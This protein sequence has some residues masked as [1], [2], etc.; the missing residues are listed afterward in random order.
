[1][2][3]RFVGQRHAVLKPGTVLGVRVVPRLRPR[4]HL[5]DERAVEL[6]APTT[7]VR[8]ERAEAWIQRHSI[9]TDARVKCAESDRRATRSE[10]VSL[11]MSISESR[12][13]TKAIL[14][15]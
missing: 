13:T 7:G 8:L 12:S 10:G 15:K 11:L 14:S 1:M 4:L 6:A 2:L 9:R 5:L 3:T